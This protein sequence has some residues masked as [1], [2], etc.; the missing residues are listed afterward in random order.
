LHVVKRN[1]DYK[2]AE[3]QTFRYTLK[4]Y[5]LK[6]RCKRHSSLRTSF[7]WVITQCVVV[8][9]HRRFG[10]TYRSHVHLNTGPIGCPEM[11]VRNYHYAL[12]NYP[13]ERSSHLLRGRSLKSRVTPFYCVLKQV[14][15]NFGCNCL[16]NSRAVFLSLLIFTSNLPAFSAF[17]PLLIPL[18]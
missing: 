12:R 16:Y 2:C 10:T 8:I 9:S 1:P 15:K 7:F 17:D 4:Y 11:S 14:K 5:V 3:C 13:E 6:F 18:D